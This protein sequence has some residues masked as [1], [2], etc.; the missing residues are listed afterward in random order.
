[1]KIHLLSDLHT[2][3]WKQDKRAK[4]MS[5]LQPA[6]VLVLAGDIAVGRSNVLEIIK[7]ID[8]T[9][10]YKHILYVPGNHEYYSGTKL[11]QFNDPS[12]V[13]KLPANAQ[14]LNPGVAIIDGVRFIGATLFT[15]FK[16]GDPLVQHA[17]KWAIQDF[18]RASGASV[19]SYTQLYQRDWAFLK[20][21]YEWRNPNDKVVFIT[22]FVPDIQLCH[23]R[24]GGETSLLNYY[25]ANRLA[26]WIAELEPCYWLFG[27]THD[28][29][30]YMIGDCRLIA[31]PYGYPGEKSFTQRIIDV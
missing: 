10:V 5:L 9:G 24:W 4:L 21:S 22:H 31:N 14:L 27:H 3:F 6:D 13:S 28:E 26:G 20:A 25:F 30:D 23:P 7:W 2:E 19:E 29:V 8:H 17:A 1:M 18:K 16:G 12:F 15:D 11:D